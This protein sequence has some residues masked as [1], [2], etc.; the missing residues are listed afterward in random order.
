M[1]K[2]KKI[3]M[4]IGSCRFLKTMKEIAWEYTR[5]G[6]I[7][8]LPN[9]RP[10]TAA[11]IDAEK[12]EAIGKS[13]IDIADLVFVCNVDGYIGNSTRVELNHALLNGKNIKYYKE[14]K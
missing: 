1:V 9:E 5:A 7:V 6:W 11:D 12:L 10:D 14:I 13:K 2:D 4:F 3:V 8:M